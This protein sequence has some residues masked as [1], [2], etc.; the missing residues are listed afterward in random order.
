MRIHHRINTI[1]QLDLILSQVLAFH[2]LPPYFSKGDFNIVRLSI[3]I[4]FKLS[5]YFRFRGLNFIRIYCFSIA[6]YFPYVPSPSLVPKIVG[7]KPSDFSGEKLKIMPSFGGEVKPSVPCRRFTTCKRTLWFTWKSK[8]QVELT[9]HFSPLLPF[10]TNRCLSYR[11][12]WSASGDDGW[13]Y[14]RCTKGL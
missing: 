9:G 8:S 14:R 1:L 4:P 2:T 6:Y 3:P 5:L 12:V 13:K 7:S 10:S 11:L